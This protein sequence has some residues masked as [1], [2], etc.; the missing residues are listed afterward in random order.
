MGDGD[1]GALIRATRTGR[2]GALDELL[3]LYRNFLRVLA[4]TSL[5][6]RFHAKADPS[7]AAQETLL[8]AYQGFDRFR[9]ESEGELVAWLKQILARHLSDVQRRFLAEARDIGRER[10]LDDVLQE[11][12][13]RLG[14]ML[15]IDEKT[16]SWRAS[17]RELS[18]IVA[19]ALAELRRDDREAIIL[20]SLH[21]MSWAEVGRRLRRSPEAAR[22][23][24][25]RALKR[26]GTVLEEKQ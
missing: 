6:P 5:D 13:L 16:P 7:D 2:P 18:V 11:S 9:G 3:G 1:I 12:S 25:F 19:D 21:E 23:L 14:R 4:R 24:W 26:L 17:R 10:R 15:P 22:L 8:K 20:R